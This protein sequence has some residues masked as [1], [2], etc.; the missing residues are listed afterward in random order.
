MI[1]GYKRPP[2]ESKKLI[3]MI[4]KIYISATE[5][6]KIRLYNHNL[7]FTNRKYANGTTLSKYIWLLRDETGKS[8]MKECDISGKSKRIK[9]IILVANYVWR[10]TDV[11]WNM[12]KIITCQTKKIQLI[13]KCGHINTFFLWHLLSE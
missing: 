9:E 4:E 7:I 6:L 5:N 8:V 2:S 3:K 11:S 12:L 13:S 1:I 10:K